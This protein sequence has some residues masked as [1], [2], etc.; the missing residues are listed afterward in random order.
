M[1]KRLYYKLSVT[2]SKILSSSQLRPPSTVWPRLA[3]LLG[4]D[5]R[6]TCYL[7]L[8]SHI[9]T[10]HWPNSCPIWEI[11]RLSKIPETD[12]QTH[13]VWPD[14]QTPKWELKIQSVVEYWRNSRG[15]KMWPNMVFRVWFIFSIESK[16][17]EKMEWIN[18]VKTP[19]RS[20]IS[21][22]IKT[23]WI[24]N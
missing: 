13:C 21:S 24:T 18:V 3:V 9:P 12:C 5:D 23:W 4:M 1:E 11:I 2:T 22:F 8:S 6:N 15:L 17:K 16:T 14:F 19:S 10:I 20:R 7:M